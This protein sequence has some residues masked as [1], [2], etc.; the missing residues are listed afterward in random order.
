M[1]P[2]CSASRA[3]SNDRTDSA[4]DALKSAIPSVTAAP[5]LA[6]QSIRDTWIVRQMSK[7]ISEFT[8][9]S[10]LR[11]VRTP[12]D[13]HTNAHMAHRL[14][15]GTYNVA[16]TIAAE[17]LDAWLVDAAK[18]DIVVIG[19]QEVDMRPQT[20][21]SGRV[22]AERETAWT[23][24][25]ADGLGANGGTNLVKLASHSLGTVAIFVYV[26]DNLLESCTASTATVG[27]GP[28]GMASKGAA[29]VRLRCV[30]RSD[31]QMDTIRRAY[32]CHD[33]VFTFV[34]AHLSAFERQVERRNQDLDVRRRLY[35]YI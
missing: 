1:G 15:I 12:P 19:L 25:T 23:K 16:E 3:V 17:P 20:L 22:S 5:A 14:F 24:A 7:R 8:Q 21:I 26:R 11:C 9:T 27:T 18:A 30:G 4:T 6:V 28:G 2:P 29:A 35:P 13:S 32:R 34:N 33:S 10:A 31:S